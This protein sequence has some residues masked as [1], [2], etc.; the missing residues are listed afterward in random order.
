[1]QYID[2]NESSE[3]QGKKTIK[4]TWSGFLQATR[5]GLAVRLRSLGQRGVASEVNSVGKNSK[6]QRVAPVA[7]EKVPSNAKKDD[8]MDDEHY[9]AFWAFSFQ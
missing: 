8:P 6:I 2:M 9:G 7:L 4:M 3:N 1:M 5:S